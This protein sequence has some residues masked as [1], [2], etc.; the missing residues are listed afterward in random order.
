MQFSHLR[1]FPGR[2]SFRAIR[3]VA[4]AGLLP[5]SLAALSGCEASTADPAVVRLAAVEAP[6]GGGKG[7]KNNQPPVADPGGPYSTGDG[8]VQLDGTASSDPDGPA[9][10]LTY[11]W[12][13]GDGANGTGSTP[14][15]AYASTGEYTVTL[16]VTDRL[17]LDSEPVTTIVTYTDTPN[18]PPVASAGGPYETSTGSVTFDG[19][20]SSDPD[21]ANENLVYAW[22]FG[23]G[24]TGVGVNPTHAYS[25]PGEYTVTLIVTDE[26]GL[27]SSPD[28]TTAV[29]SEDGGGPGATRTS[30][31]A[32]AWGS[33]S[34]WGGEPPPGDGDQAV[35]QHAVTVGSAVTVGQHS[36]GGGSLDLDVQAGG[37]LAVLPGATLRVKGNIEYAGALRVDAGAAL[38]QD[39][40]TGEVYTVNV[41]TG[42]PSS[43][44]IEVRGTSGNPGTVDLNAG[45][46]TG[47]LAPLQIAGNGVLDFE[48]GV[49]RGGDAG[50]LNRVRVRGDQ[51]YRLVHSRIENS[52]GIY[53]LSPVPSGGRIT[54]ENTT[55]VGTVT[56]ESLRLNR[57]D[58]PS[59]PGTTR[60]VH[61]VFDRKAF[62]EGPDALVDG[63]YLA[64]GLITTAGAT[65]YPRVVKNS[66]VRRTAQSFMNIT[67]DYRD[68]IHLED[69][70]FS[71]PHGVQVNLNAVS[72]TIAG[73]VFKYAGTSTAG[74][75]IAPRSTNPSPVTMLVSGNLVLPN[76]NGSG[77]SGTLISLLGDQLWT[78]RIERNTYPTL[79]S[80]GGI[81][82]AETYDGHAGYVPTINSNLAYG[83][84]T[85]SGSV[86]H[87]VHSGIAD[88]YVTEADYNGYH[89]VNVAYDAPASA[90]ANSPGSSD[91]AGDPMFVD[92]SRDLTTYDLLRGGNGTVAHLL[93]EVARMNDAGFDPAYSP[94]AIRAWIMDGYRP[95]NSAFQGAG[96][97]GIDIGAVPF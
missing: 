60:F 26:Q 39:A 74:D 7:K 70:S 58:D 76:G 5:L 62:I 94:A 13:F 82:I 65:V 15:H 22:T 2:R 32:G 80:S 38:L 88:D 45:T 66:L 44:V 61:S 64:E 48:Y 55:W 8:T 67:G 14:V 75:M 40:P 97:G 12:Y 35:V 36:S 10:K 86:V 77:P 47:V 33:A 28:N 16:T 17:G 20:G 89:N 6:K 25:S 34:T 29:Y 53:Q 83:M 4:Y 95:L 68:N 72:S 51:H 71:N 69:H 31:Q 27:D 37:S 78:V 11:L 24:G 3:S 41:R 91:V 18:E 63:C 23:D 87:Q 92:A 57:W 43:A 19:S 50:N 54:V 85:N 96:K 42:A 81:A 84:G 56:A 73:T 79:G 30:T 1:P 52:A 90:F 21:G 46:G 59:V 49:F 9:S 93:S